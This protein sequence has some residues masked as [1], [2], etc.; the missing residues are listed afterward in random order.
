MKDERRRAPIGSSHPSSFSLLALL[1]ALTAAA[2]ASDE[3]YAW[4]LDLPRV[5]TG[6]FG[7]YRG[8]RFHAGMDLMTGENGRPIHAPADGHVMRVTCSP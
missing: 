5:V 8:G 3:P 7:E 4:P 1:C 6:T 2:A